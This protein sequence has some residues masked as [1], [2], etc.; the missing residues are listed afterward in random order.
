VG[1]I[2][3]PGWYILLF[4]PG[5]DEVMVPQFLRIRE[6]VKV[7]II[8]ISCDEC[9]L[10]VGEI[11]RNIMLAHVGHRI[12]QLLV[13]VAVQVNAVVVDFIDDNT[14]CFPPFTGSN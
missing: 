10:S 1:T 2:F 11:F 5:L 13:G 8:D 7:D 6:V 3:R 4:V 12:F 14:N 9:K